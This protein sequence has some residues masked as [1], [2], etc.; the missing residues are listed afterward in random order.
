MKT[1][2]V[3]GAGLFLKLGNS[4]KMKK[5]ILKFGASRPNANGSQSVCIYLLTCVD[6]NIML[7]SYKQTLNSVTIVV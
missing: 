4:N 7:L 5:K 1:K 3:C 2:L 6:N